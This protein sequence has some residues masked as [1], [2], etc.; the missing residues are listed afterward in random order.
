MT[1]GTIVS[2][3]GLLGPGAASLAAQVDHLAGPLTAGASLSRF[4]PDGTGAATLRWRRE[5]VLLAELARDLGDEVLT[6]AVHEAGRSLGDVRFDPWSAAGT[7]LPVWWPARSPLT[8]PAAV[9][10]T[11]GTADGSL[12]AEEVAGAV[13]LVLVEGSFG[14]LLYVLGA[15]K[16]RLRRQARAVAAARVLDL[17]HGEAL[18]RHGRDTALPRLATR[19]QGAGG[20]LVLASAPEDD[21]HYRERLRLYRGLRL[22]THRTL[23]EHLNGPDGS[24]GPNT[25]PVA[26]LDPGRTAPLGR[27]TVLDRPAPFAVAVRLVA[28]GDPGLRDSFL[29]WLRR[30]RLVRPAAEGDAD[31]AARLLPPEA[32][33]RL[34]QLRATLRAG[35]TFVDGAAADPAFAP[36]LAAALGRLAACRAA[37]GVPDPWP[38]SAAQADTGSRYELGLGADLAVLP[39]ADLDDLAAR[40]AAF[41]PGPDTD[42]TAA[43]LLAAAVPLASADDEEGR[44]L[45]RLCGLRTVHRTGAGTLHVSPVHSGGLVLEGAPVVQPGG[46]DDVALSA[47]AGDGVRLVLGERASGRIDLLALG[48]PGRA[49]VR[50]AVPAGAQLVGL[51]AS[52]TRGL[53]LYSR[54][55]GTFSVVHAGSGETLLAPVD[56]GTRWTLVLGGHLVSAPG[57]DVPGDLVLY[58]TVSGDL[59]VHRIAGGAL[60]PVRT[61]PGW[62]PGWTSLAVGTLQFDPTRDGAG[63]RPVLLAYD[64]VTGSVEAVDLHRG[65]PAPVL[66]LP[67]WRPGLS[68]LV[69]TGAGRRRRGPGQ[70]LVAFDRARG[71]LAV[72]E[73]EVDGDAVRA[74]RRLGGST[75]WEGWTT[76]VGLPGALDLGTVAVVLTD[77]GTGRARWVDL[78]VPADPGAEDLSPG[79]RARPREQYR[80]HL[81]GAGDERAAELLRSGLDRAAGEWAAAGR[82][83]WTVLAPAELPGLLAVLQPATG[84]AAAGLADAG[85]PHPGHPDALAAAPELPAEL[86]GVLRLD[87][88]LAADVAA[89]LAVDRLRGLLEL[90]SDAGMA[91]GLLFLTGAGDAVVV[92]S[93]VPLP[94]AGLNLAE[95]ATAEFRWYAVPVVGD[96]GRVRERGAV[97]EFSPTGRGLTALV[98]V[99]TERGAAPAPFGLRVEP[100]PGAALSPDEYEFVMNVLLADVPAAVEVD[101]YPIRSRAVD[102]HGDGTGGAIPPRL[103]RSFQLY[104][105]PGARPAGRTATPG[106]QP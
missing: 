94:V 57:W 65:E 49:P 36:S 71:E 53:G 1:P 50:L 5:P 63:E 68:G 18:D 51:P 82:P 10:V 105:R 6:V 8:E 12:P 77:P 60:V 74:L 21:A 46:W 56:V 95:R 52:S 80:A 90:L 47:G 88:G 41:T 64:A 42:P 93:L 13:C 38:L 24:S 9:V 79:W 81:L 54:E 31:T 83:P 2:G 72:Y 89:G 75:G 26:G 78:T 27:F 92:T 99:G 101:T 22:P 84:A 28:A 69:F 97:T 55:D 35:F 43:A 104:R 85:M 103:A 20:E 30:D 48:G 91:A 19:L 67:D 70:P 73:A 44:W 33:V 87:P 4:P 62:R 25:G 106:G 16:A 96:G 3:A 100:P 98:A 32:R 61:L 14:R 102:V 45:L 15:E 11:A 58:D 66:S 40:A 23:R 59:A 29:G 37:L 34:E 17:A 7:T 86:V 76:V 39:A